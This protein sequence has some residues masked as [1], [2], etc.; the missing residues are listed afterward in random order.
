MKRILLTLFIALL[1]SGAVLDTKSYIVGDQKKLDATFSQSGEFETEAEAK[2]AMDSTLEMN[3]LHSESVMNRYYKLPNK[4]YLNVTM[5]S[6]THKMSSYL[7]T[8]LIE[9]D[10]AHSSTLTFPEHDFELVSVNHQFKQKAWDVE[11]KAGQL[12]FNIGDFSNSKLEDRMVVSEDDSAGVSVSMTPKKGVITVNRNGLWLD[13][14]NFK[15]G[16]NEKL[17]TFTS[18]NE[19]VKAVQQDDFGKEIGVIKTDE[20][21]F[22][23]FY[24]AVSDYNEYTVI[25]VET[26]G[27]IKAGKFERF[28]FH[29]DIVDAKTE[30]KVDGVT[31]QLHFQQ[32]KDKNKSYKNKVEH[33]KMD[34]GVEVG[35]VDDAK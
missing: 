26:H 18:E 29:E 30:E 5:L 25:P 14:A 2:E 1:V 19:A 4:H 34:I 3:D 20:M 11:S 28:T 24:N 32:G 15:V 21:N 12:H 35:G 31:Y 17:R 13:H 8:G 22:H 33:K 7:Y 27:E 23:I 10:D 9:T 6:P 16:M